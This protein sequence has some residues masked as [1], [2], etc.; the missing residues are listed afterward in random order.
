MSHPSAT[1][2]HL[3]IGW[4]ATDITP[5]R[6]VL[7]A[8]QFHARVSEGVADPVTATALAIQRG[9]ELAVLVSCD[10]VAISDE[11]RDAVR[12]LVKG[13]LPDLDPT[14]VVLHATHTHTGPEIREP[15][16]GAGHVSMGTGVD[17][18]VWPPEEYIPWA[19]ARVGE[20][21]TQAWERRTAGGVAFGLGHAVI[22]HNRRWVDTGG[23]ATMYGNTSSPAFSHIEGY[24]DHRVSTLATYG[25]DG[26]LTGL[27][28]NVPCPAQVSEGDYR[29]SADYWH[30]TRMEL[31]HRLGDELHILPQCSVAGD[32]SP[33]P[34][35]G[36]SAEQRMLSLK[37]RSERQEIA[38]RIADAVE[39][40]L[41][42]VHDS[43]ERQP[44]MRHCVETL[45]LPMTSLDDAA[46]ATAREEADKLQ[47]VHE[48][49]LD[50]LRRD[51]GLRNQPR[52]YVPVTRAFRRMQW[53]RG[54]I[55]RHARSMDNNT[56]PAEVHILR[57][58]D[59][60][61]ATNPF[62]YYLDFGMCIRA[63]SPAAQTFL[64]QLAGGGTYV[65]SPR[66]LAGGG[67]GSIPAS[68]PVGPEGGRQLAERT[69]EVLEELF[70]PA[71]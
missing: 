7:I 5:E 49:E 53:F 12:G 38:V 39:A 2:E 10:L 33:H 62:E 67:Y 63:R 22:G 58:G 24:E 52:W 64:V 55:E 14:R 65:P 71:E 8:G 20:V 4:A 43:I 47:H 69:V 48:E 50:K 40:T 19:A 18:E 16:L 37:G 13:R 31:R 26:S 23:N 6:P 17:L 44:T 51:P 32:Q 34:I 1:E 30:E 15:T 54:V 66:S 36:K 35:L 45:D 28:V 59:M 70:P 60:A 56:R 11:L 25:T 41:P 46:V 21:V 27:V 61:M 3:Q 42:H 29:L 57:L 68:N 9:H